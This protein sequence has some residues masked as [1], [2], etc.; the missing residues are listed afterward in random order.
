MIQFKHIITKTKVEYADYAIEMYVG[1]SNDCNYCF[2]KGIAKRYWGFEDWTKPIPKFEPEITL[3]KLRDELEKLEAKTK[4]P[5]KSKIVLSFMT[6]PFQPIETEYR[7]T[8]K[9]L[10][11]LRDWEFDIWILTK[12]T[13]YALPYSVFDY[14]ALMKEIPNCHYGVTITT[15]EYWDHEPNAINPWL[16]LGS[17]FVAKKEYGLDTWISFE[18]IRQNLLS[19]LKNPLIQECCDFYVFGK[20]NP[21]KKF[22]AVLELEV[23]PGIEFL[24]AQGKSFLIKNELREVL[25][26]TEKDEPARCASCG[27]VTE[28][29]LY[30]AHHKER[31]C[32]ECL[33]KNDNRRPKGKNL[34]S[35]F[36]K[37]K[38]E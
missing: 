6:D 21:G 27:K 14:F 5:M 20:Q 34:D 32:Q 36:Q 37:S 1:C 22:D 17:L 3:E 11:E 30:A 33:P 12:S 16:R 23:P 35:F 9:I 31:I 29:L 2:A 28:K 4:E 10:R 13:P 7:I 19:M 15:L 38:E 8:A 25:G 24:K 18:P 26:I